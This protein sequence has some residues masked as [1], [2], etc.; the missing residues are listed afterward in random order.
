MCG[1]ACLAVP[2][3]VKHV[4]HCAETHFVGF[5]FRTPLPNGKVEF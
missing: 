5:T 1:S 4:L 2:Q 3:R